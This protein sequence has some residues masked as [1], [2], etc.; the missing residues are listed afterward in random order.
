MS[1][2]SARLGGKEKATGS[3]NSCAIGLDAHQS[4]GNWI[5]AVKSLRPCNQI[6]SLLHCMLGLTLLALYVVGTT[7]PFDQLLVSASS[8]DRSS[9]TRMRSALAIAERK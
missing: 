4:P 1:K 7:L 6:L 3:E 5:E 2:A 8:C 9:N